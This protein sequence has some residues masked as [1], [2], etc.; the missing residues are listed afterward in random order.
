MLRGHHCVELDVVQYY[1]AWPTG[2]QQAFENLEQHI[3]PPAVWQIIRHLRARDS[4]R[5][6]VFLWLKSNDNF[7]EYDKMSSKR[8]ILI[9]SYPYVQPVI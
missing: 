1:N 7:K 5:S 4:A 8:N 9:T 2:Q 3:E 6:E